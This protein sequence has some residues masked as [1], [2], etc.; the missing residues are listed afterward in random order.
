MRAR[1]RELDRERNP[2]EP[3]NDLADGRRVVVVVRLRVR[4][5]AHALYEERDRAVVQRARRGEGDVR[6]RIRERRDGAHELA[7]DAEPLARRRDRV[8][9]GTRLQQRLDDLGD[10]VEEMLAV[11]EDEQ[12][13]LRAQMRENPGARGADVGD[14]RLDGLRDAID[15]GIVGRERGELDEPDAV[16]KALQHVGAELQAESLSSRRRPRP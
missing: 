15:E 6:G 4:R 13:A 11:V 7:R 14:R 5:R 2:F 16:G 9:A 8:D 1:G 10:A 12:R 3:A